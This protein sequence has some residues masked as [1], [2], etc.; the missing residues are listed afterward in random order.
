MVFVI[1]GLLLAALKYAEVSPVA[2]WSW[3]VVLAPFGLA[4]VWWWWADKS[5]YDKRKAMEAMEER[6]DKRRRDH[7]GAM[8]LK[9]TP[10][11]K[12]VAEREKAARQ[13]NIDK[14]EGERERRRK[15]NRDSI[16]SSVLPD[17]RFDGASTPAAEHD[18]D[19]Q[20]KTR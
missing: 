12:K 11:E 19:P 2:G 17:S 5:G 7:L 10:G 13:R 3:L 1:L 16:L 20:R 6:K 18:Q 14:V 15:A 9:V 8:G 4:L